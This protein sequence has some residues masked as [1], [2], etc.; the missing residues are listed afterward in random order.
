MNSFLLCSVK[1]YELKRFIG[2]IF[3]SKCS[4]IMND[5]WMIYVTDSTSFIVIDTNLY[6][7]LRHLIDDRE[8]TLVLTA[9]NRCKL[10]SLSSVAPPFYPNT[11]LP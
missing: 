10:D 7:L 8:V 6:L 3:L 5:K 2:G 4:I 9:F 11:N 1:R